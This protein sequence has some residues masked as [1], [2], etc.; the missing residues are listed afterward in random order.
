[1]TNFVKTK[2]YELMVTE[3]RQMQF[4]K[5]KDRGHNE[6][7]QVLFKYILTKL[8]NMTMMRNFEVMLGQTQNHSVQNC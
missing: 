2:K 6:Y 7:L 4:G 3:L 8:L 1:M 5:V